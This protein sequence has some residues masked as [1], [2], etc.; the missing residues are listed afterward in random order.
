MMESIQKTWLATSL[1]LK[2]LN[3]D[4][5]GVTTV[6]YAVMLV[7]VAIAVIIAAP[8]ISAAVLAVFTQIATQLQPVATP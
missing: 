5:R 3:S 8:N 7:L 2:T 1:W 4:E 6:E